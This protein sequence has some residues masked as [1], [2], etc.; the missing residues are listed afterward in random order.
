LEAVHF[1]LFPKL[2]KRGKVPQCSCAQLDPKTN[3][4]VTLL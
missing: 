2:Y 4:V 3:T 1:Y